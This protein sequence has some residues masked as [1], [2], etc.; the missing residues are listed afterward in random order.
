MAATNVPQTQSPEEP[1]VGGVRM[2]PSLTLLLYALLVASAAVALWAQRAPA[3]VPLAA[4]R[5]APW[6]FLIF[7]IGFAA[8]RFALVAVKRYSA[9]KAFFQV[10]ITAVFFLLLLP[11]GPVTPAVS[12]PNAV[13]DMM[14]LLADPD[15]RVRALAAELAR[16]RP[17][18]PETAHMLVG[19]LTDT[20]PHVR[21]LAHESLVSLNS[22]QDL[23]DGRDRTSRD[24][25][26]KRF[27]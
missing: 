12:T 25:W 21:T 20:D 3:D 2:R 4:A 13:G 16:Y 22:G 5:S 17:A 7:A 9:F 8:Y 26:G 24:A 23:G 15:A 27:P 11:G 1:S 10:A 6:V 19:V 14:G 18:T